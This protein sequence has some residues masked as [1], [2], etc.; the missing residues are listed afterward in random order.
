MMPYIDGDF[1]TPSQ[2]GPTLVRVDPLTGSNIYSHTF[3]QLASDYTPSPLGDAGIENDSLIVSISETSGIG[4]GVVQWTEEHAALPA[5]FEKY[6]SFV[7][8]HQFI[9]GSSPYNI[10]E[11]SRA[12]ITRVEY[13]ALLPSDIEAATILRAYRITRAQLGT[14]TYYFYTGTHSDD[15]FACEDSTIQQWIGPIYLL[16][17]RYAKEASFSSL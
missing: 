12:E 14:T 15:E 3:V 8:T 16:K 11:L 7:V 13:T 2:T 17:T 10:G 9:A 4:G 5:D 6:E 1:S